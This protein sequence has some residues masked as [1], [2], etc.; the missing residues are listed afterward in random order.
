MKE[1]NKVL[2]ANRAE[3]ALRVIKTCRNL[4]IKTVTLYTFEE[5][6]LPQREFADES[7][8]LEGN[9]LS[10]TYLNM[11]KIIQIAKDSGCDAI[12]PGYGFLSENAE[13][14][15]KVTDAGLI[16]IGPTP[17]HIILMGDKKG[18]K[19]KMIE[20]GVPVIPGYNGENQ[21]PELLKSQADKMGYPVLI[22]ASAGGGGKGMR[23]VE[24]SQDF[25][26]E[27]ESCKREALSSF[28]SDIVLIE[29]FITSPRHIEIQVVSD[30]HGNHFHFFEREC[31]IQRR[32]QKIIEETPSLALGDELR[33]AMTDAAIKITKS[34]NYHGAG[35]IELILD[36]NEFYFLEMNTRLQVE[37]PV[38]E[39]VT[40][41]DLVDLQLIAASGKAFDFTQDD[42][43]Q[44]GHAIECRIYA[45]DPD[46]DFMPAIGRLEYIGDA[47]DGVRL[48]T[49]YKNGNSI[50]VNF[51]PMIAKV[52]TWG[53]DRDEAIGTMIA[54]LNH[55]PFEGLTTNNDYLVRILKHDAFLKGDTYTHFVKTYEEDLAPAEVYAEEI[56]AT[57]AH[58]FLRDNI[59]FDSFRMSGEALETRHYIVDGNELTAT[60]KF[61]G[62]SS[63][64][65]RFF[66][67]TFAVDIEE[68][69]LWVNDVPFHILTQK[70]AYIVNSKR[71]EAKRL[72]AKRS[73]AATG[74]AGDMSS[75]MPGK[76]LKVLV[77]AGQ[78]VSV[79]DALIVMEAMKME[80]TVKA[81]RDGKVDAILVN[82]GQTIDGGVELVELA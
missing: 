1:I 14:S 58:D 44:I 80:H 76:V 59:L 8:Y 56:A 19:D 33:K 40:G 49:G 35:T 28:G 55:L 79:G 67:F 27:L 12:H 57:L 82:E 30:T 68:D 22:K 24:S 31:S 45:E 23:I 6:N 64:I 15:Q 74:E 25:L 71:V 39:M 81:S 36:G 53:A 47:I 78:S 18:S 75:P 9:L 32:H 42:I 29:K 60:F 20:I 5:R 37:H 77:E 7:Y 46:N 13:F 63:L 26:A 52:I 72:V 54:G 34:I 66:D 62:V 16:F 70:N 17:E 61:S 69:A 38:T 21:D 11:D 2:I 50:T 51:D 65:V 73:G 43:R 3:I 41:F 4:G 10:E 48:D